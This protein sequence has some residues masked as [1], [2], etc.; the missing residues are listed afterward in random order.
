MQ[1]SANICANGGNVENTDQRKAPLLVSK[2]EA[3]AMLGV[4]L[5]S[6]DNYVSAKELPCRRLGKRVL[7]PYAALVHFARHDHITETE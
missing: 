6:I 1:S 2:R 3:A 4:C 5:R 7:I